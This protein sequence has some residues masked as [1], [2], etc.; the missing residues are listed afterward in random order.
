MQDRVYALLKERIADGRVQ[1]G[2]K[3]LEVQV[4]KAFGV[5]RSPARHALQA[6]SSERLIKPADGRGY[7]VAG[8]ALSDA[9]GQ[10]ATLE[11]IPLAPAP[12]WERVYAKVEQELCTRVLFRSVRITEERLAEHF[13]VSRTVAR[14][15]LGRMHGVGLVSKDRMGRW[16]GEQVTMSRIR[17]LYEMRWL[18]EPQ[19]LLQSAP[20]VP[21]E[22]VAGA[23]DAIKRTLADLPRTDS[24]ELDRLENDL[25]VDLLAKCPNEEI[26]RA[27]GHTHLLL[28][29]NRYMFDNYLGIPPEIESSLRE[30]LDV[31]ERLLRKDWARAA[32]ALCEHLK[33]SCGHWQR[34]FETISALKQPQLPPYISPIETHLSM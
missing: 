27:L 11:E 7:V 33:R 17:D 9:S 5:S 4:A 19:A 10:L 8:R 13:G 18:L 29:S 6:L 23:R 22:R 2:E 25:H 3:L 20:L 14:D 24:P 15:V 31:V 26:L 30:H 12:R 16:I 32:A 1:P 28:V 34:R 21:R